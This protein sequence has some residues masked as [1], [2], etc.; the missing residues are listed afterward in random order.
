MLVLAAAGCAKSTP[1]G[2]PTDTETSPPPP[3]DVASAEATWREAAIQN[4]TLDVTITGCMMCGE[5]L[6]YKLTVTSG[7]VTDQTVPSLMKDETAPTV[8]DLFHLIES[9]GPDDSKVKY[10]DVGV[11]V[12]IDVDAPEVSDDQ[13]H[14][15]VTFTRT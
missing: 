5:P 7:K 13:A 12:D 2:S 3:S 8:D 15:E 1:A 10:N 9:Y 4:Y 11:P 14:Y 6:R